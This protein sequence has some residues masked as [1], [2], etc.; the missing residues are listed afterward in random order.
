MI[1]RALMREKSKKQAPQIS[2]D[3][4]LFEG[5]LETPTNNYTYDEY[6]EIT[7]DA[8]VSLVRSLA[9][10]PILASNWSIESKS[11]ED[12]GISE[13]ELEERIERLEEDL[14][15]IRYSFLLQA[16]TYL[17]DYGWMP[18]EK[19]WRKD[20]EGYI[21]IHKM[22][23]LLHDHTYILI[24]KNGSFQGFQQDDMD[25]TV[26]PLNKS[27][28]LSQ[29]VEGTNWYG[30]AKLEATGKAT[31]DWDDC[32]DGAS[33]YDKKVAGS[34]WVVYYPIGETPDPNGVLKDNF[35]IAGDILNSLESSGKMRIPSSVQSE[36]E[37][38][39]E[40]LEDGESAWRVETVSDNM[41]RQHS[42]VTRLEYLDKL[43]VRGYG[44]TEDAVLK[45]RYSPKTEQGVHANILATSQDLQHQY[46]VDMLNKH[47]IDQ[48]LS[49]NYGKNMKGTIFV[50]P[51][52]ITNMSLTFL[53]DVYKMLLNNQIVVTAEA[54]NIDMPELRTKVG[55]PHEGGELVVSEDPK[56]LDQPKKN[57]EDPTEEGSFKAEGVQN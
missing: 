24:D 5:Q 14:N 7:K 42:F 30:R 44:F 51:A 35:E 22:K 11:A 41:A 48:T 3:D 36:I 49:Y 55:L 38:M 29:D 28:L 31:K 16:V 32:N 27:L 26:I 33:R 57:V 4:L 8:T 47:V 18:Y 52:P 21:R 40:G 20:E 23:P 43:K 2:I 56:N 50:V 25:E 17:N 6:R 19:I 12:I 9:P 37:R 10:G 15:R 46:I 54:N 45:T 34:H 1:Q 13:E 53:Q 39:G